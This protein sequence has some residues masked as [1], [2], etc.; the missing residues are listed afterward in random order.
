MMAASRDDAAVRLTIKVRPGSARTSVGGFQELATAGEPVDAG[1]G[2]ALI[3]HVT[4]PAVDG[5]ATEAALRALATAFGVRR[6]EVVLV[7]GATNRMKI[8]EIGGLPEPEL[9]GRLAEL[10]VGPDRPPDRPGAS[11]RTRTS[12]RKDQSPR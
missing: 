3:V 8:V 6:R 10:G 9:R 2:L 12:S 5:R 11:V 1:G 4:V 7:T